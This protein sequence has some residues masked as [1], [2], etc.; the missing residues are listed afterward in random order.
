MT[1]G[2][3]TFY[4]LHS[5]S[6]SSPN[7]CEKRRLHVFVRLNLFPLGLWLLHK[8]TQYTHWFFLTYPFLQCARAIPVAWLGSGSCHNRPSGWILMMMMILSSSF[9]FLLLSL[10][11]PIYTPFFLSPVTFCLWL[12]CWCPVPVNQWFRET[13]KIRDLFAG[14]RWMYFCND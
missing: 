11:L 3:R 2:L 7:N 9:A 4:S 1:N 6:I 14:H 12:V 13:Q 5:A 10:Q 8:L